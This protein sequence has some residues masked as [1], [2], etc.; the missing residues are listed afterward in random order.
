M[1]LSALFL[2]LFLFQHF[3]INLT[4]V[5]PDNGKTFNNISHFMG[6]NIIVQFFI[7]PV[8][9]IAI[10]YHFVMGIMLE[11]YN[12]SARNVKYKMYKGKAN[13]TWVSRNMIWTGAVILAF[14]VLH[15]IDFWIPEMQYKYIE[16]N[17]S[18]TDRYYE[19]MVHRFQNP[20]RVLFYVV[21]FFLLAMHLKHGFWSAFQSIG[22]DS[23][24]WMQMIKKFGKAYAILIP[25]GFIF[26]ALFHY[27]AH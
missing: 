23:P 18:I 25:L 22:V 4:S 20:V 5:L 24:R 17:P 27:F 13:S 3:V 19:E 7:Q 26:I 6:N 10:I 1:A 14:L 12:Q 2:L 16:M 8:L 11:T 9:V 15:F 21:S